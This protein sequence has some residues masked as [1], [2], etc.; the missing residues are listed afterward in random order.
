MPKPSRHSD[1]G[2]DDVRSELPLSPDRAQCA[3]MLAAMLMVTDQELRALA[4]GESVIAF[5]ARNTVSEGD[6][7]E[8]TSGSSLPAD[9][10]KPAYRRWA[11]AGPPAGPWSAVVE[12]VE[13]AASLDPVAGASRHVLSESGQ[14]DMV[15][16]RVFASSGPVLSEVAFDARVRSVSGA[17]IP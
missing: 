17:L 11:D 10:L 14:G 7:V 1:S 6:E 13:P 8:L 12:S 4:S 15:V 16:L 3:P 2:A 5:V 9:R